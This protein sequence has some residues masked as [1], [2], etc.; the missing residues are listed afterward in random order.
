[1]SNFKKINVAIVGC[2]HIA[3]KHALILTSKKNKKFNLVAVCDINK[4]KAKNFGKK[5][6]INFFYNIDNLL[7]STNVDLVVICTSSGYHYE[8]AMTVSKYKKNVVIEK[9]ICLNL[10][11]AKKVVKRSAWERRVKA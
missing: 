4:E 7:K 6:K 5:F 2:G 9:P 3:Q 10:F 8:N 1:M 11:E